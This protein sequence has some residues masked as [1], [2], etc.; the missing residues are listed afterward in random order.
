MLISIVIPTRD[1]AEVLQHAL[2][3]CARI[4]DPQLEIIVS[5][6]SS[7]DNTADVVAE[8]KDSRIRYVCTPQRYSMRQNFE[9][10][11]SHAGGDYIFTLGDDDAPLPNQFPYLRALLERHTPDTL[12]GSFIRYIWPTPMGPE[13]QGRIRLKF[14]SLYGT[15]NIVSGEQVRSDLERNG[16]AAGRYAPGIYRGIA[17]RRV[18][19]GL[20]AKTG[21]VFMATWPDIY[22]TFASPALIERHLTVP[23]PFIVSGSSSRSNGASFH[24][25]KRNEGEAK[26]TKK[27]LAEASTDPVVDLIPA[28]WSL[29]AGMLSHLESAN[30]YAFGGSLHID[31]EREFERAVRSLD[32]LPESRR[33][34]AAG[35]LARFAAERN[36]APELCDAE[37]LLSRCKPVSKQPGSRK[38]GKVR[39]YLTMDRVVVDLSSASRTD[40]D[41]A[42]AAYEDLIGQRPVY[43]G[44]ARWVAWAQLL[45]RAL[46]LMRRLSLRLPM[47]AS[48]PPASSA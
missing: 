3:A 14:K 38:G 45:R 26:E 24:R 39:S 19:E 41:A 35:A 25:T 13:N 34:V 31:Y 20:R 4:R 7:V 10:G 43:G 18:V 17:S 21:Q 28:T 16:T 30:R 15:C 37:A 5:D 44:V 36:L 33:E 40:I 48:V 9:F 22:F 23:H 47:Q 2:A 27:V 29:Q 1:R 6:N 32:E 12:T 42:V 8:F 46:K 11:V